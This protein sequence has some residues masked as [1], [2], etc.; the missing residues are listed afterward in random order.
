[1][2]RIAWVLLSVGSVA[3]GQASTVSPAETG[4]AGAPAVAGS[5]SGG[6][7]AQAGEAGQGTVG[8]MSSGSSSAG[9]SGAPTD[10][11][12]AES[13]GGNGGAASDAGTTPAEGDA[14][15][16]DH[17]QV[18]CRIALQPCPGLQVRTVVDRCYGDCVDVGRCACDAPDDCTDEGQ[19]TCIRSTG[20]CTPYLR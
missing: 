13:Q 8:G 4:G 5:G 20:R 10:N 18:T 3:C 7:D 15:D 11:G 6:S 16:C 12:G 19:Y 17:K 9:S 14:L 1:M 2:W